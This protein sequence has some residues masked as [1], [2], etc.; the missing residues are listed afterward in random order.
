ME[1][2]AP[3]C[4]DYSNYMGL[5]PGQG[6]KILQARQHGQNEKKK[7]KGNLYVHDWKD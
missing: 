7:W 3:L 1:F 4:N 6:I 5:I 2:I